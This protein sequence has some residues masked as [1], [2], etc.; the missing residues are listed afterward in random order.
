MKGGHERDTAP[1]LPL[2]ATKGYDSVVWSRLYSRDTSDL[3]D[4][5]IN[6]VSSP[7]TDH[8]HFVKENGH[9]VLIDKFTHFGFQIH[10]ILEE[11]LQAVGAKAMVVGHTPQ[12]A[13][14]NW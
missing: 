9:Y 2:I 1:S 8:L 14:V 11:T 13:G 6:Q 12:I 7:L 3:L 4:Y 10:R 5:Q